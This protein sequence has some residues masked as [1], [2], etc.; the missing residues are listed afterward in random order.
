MHSQRGFTL[1]EIMIALVI[2]TF[3]ILGLGTATATALRVVTLSDRAT[4]AIQL[5]DGRIEEIQMDPNYNG[6]DTLYAGTESS[7]PDLPG[8]TRETVIVRVGGLGQTQ[9]YKTVTVKVNGPGLSDPI[10]RTITVA[11]P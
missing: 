5:A 2:L 8:Y 1:I 6:L 4:A 9:D 3:V 10:S 11:A 7:F